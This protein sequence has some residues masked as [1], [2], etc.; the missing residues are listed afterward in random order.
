MASGVEDLIRQELELLS[1]RD[2]GFWGG[3]ARDL[4]PR[5]HPAAPAVNTKQQLSR[6]RRRLVVFAVWSS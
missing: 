2:D 4:P 6:R 5:G 3:V 1:P